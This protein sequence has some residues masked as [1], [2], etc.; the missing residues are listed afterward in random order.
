MRWRMAAVYISETGPF[1][2]SSTPNGAGAAILALVSRVNPYFLKVEIPAMRLRLKIL[3]SLKPAAVALAFTV[4]A[5]DR[6]V[7]ASEQQAPQQSPPIAAAQAEPKGPELRV[8]A[9]EAVRMAL[10]NNLGVR[11]E[12][13]GPQIGTYGVAQARAAYA[14]N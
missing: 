5:S 2:P 7:F 14:P 10:E 3:A 8:T 12:K 4:S 13:L 9:D 11:A 1:G 6:V